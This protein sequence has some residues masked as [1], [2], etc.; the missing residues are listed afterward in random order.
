MNYFLALLFLVFV[1]L[2]SISQSGWILNPEAPSGPFARP[3]SF[4]YVKDGS[5]NEGADKLFSCKLHK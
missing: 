2:I 5:S 3:D 4:I 1:S